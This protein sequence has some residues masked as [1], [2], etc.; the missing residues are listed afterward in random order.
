MI[1]GQQQERDLYSR[2]P[3]PHTQTISKARGPRP[4]PFWP[5]GSKG[6]VQG[7]P[8]DRLRPAPRRPPPPPAGGRLRGGG[9]GGGPETGRAIKKGGLYSV[10][11][12]SGNFD[13]KPLGKER[14]P[15]IGRFP[16]PVSVPA[17]A[18]HRD[19]DERRG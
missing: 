1:A 15:E 14:G 3:I 16:V 9:G 6:D 13:H 5:Y 19:A 17:A 7:R 4:R 18:S 10:Y 8:R 12:V 11:E 2:R